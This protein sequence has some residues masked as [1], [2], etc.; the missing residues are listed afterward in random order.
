MIVPRLRV[1]TERISCSQN[2]LP[3][4]ELIQLALLECQCPMY[5]P[6]RFLVVD[7]NAINVKVLTKI[8]QKLY[9]RAYISLTMDLTQV[10][11]KLELVDVV[12][13]DIDMPVLTGIQL[14]SRIRSHP[15]Y[16][17]MGV[18]AVTTRVLNSDLE[19]Y[20]SVG[21][22]YTIPKPIKIGYDAI[23]AHIGEI[24]ATRNEL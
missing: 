15:Q 14:A 18:V 12:F 5:T 1:D 23:L 8:L 6:Y 13:L 11:K 10:L 19:L 16:D 7:D 2:D 3:V 22:D 9:P 24:I 4:E 21:I 20:T 17:K